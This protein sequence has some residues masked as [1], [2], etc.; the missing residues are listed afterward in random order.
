MLF[1]TRQPGAMAEAI[2]RVTLDAGLRQR[3]AAGARAAI[4]EQGLTWQHNAWRVSQLFDELLARR[5]R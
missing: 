1:D 3:I 2:E 5:T 4:A